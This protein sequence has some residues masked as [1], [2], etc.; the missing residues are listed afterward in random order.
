MVPKHPTFEF[1]F[2]YWIFAWFLIYYFGFT[3]YNPKIWLIIALIINI[4]NYLFGYNKNKNYFLNILYFIINFF[5]KII[6]L[7]LLFNTKIKFSDFIAGLVLLNVFFLWLLFRMGSIK[8]IIQ[9]F[10]MLFKKEKN[11]KP[12]TPLINFFIQK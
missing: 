4:Y 11:N 2:S 12:S 1:T 6:P 3:K 7:Y 9:Y 5:I 10:K 8:N